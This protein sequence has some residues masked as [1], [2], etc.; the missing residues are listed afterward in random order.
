MGLYSLRIGIRCIT[1]KDVLKEGYDRL[2][3]LD[4]G[5]KVRVALLLVVGKKLWRSLG[6]LPENWVSKAL[7]GV[8][9]E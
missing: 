8:A 3:L 6:C 4:I 9:S 7:E 1:E 5:M 2:N